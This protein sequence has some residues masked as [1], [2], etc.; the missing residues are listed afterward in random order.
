MR[1]L[2]ARHLPTVFSACWA[3]HTMLLRGELVAFW[4]FI[5]AFLPLLVGIVFVFHGF[6][7]RIFAHGFGVLP[8]KHLR[9]PLAH[10]QHI[11]LLALEEV[12]PRR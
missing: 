12:V 3:R 10:S 6:E 2:R 4:V 9:E 11:R 7:L 1:K 8:V 5:T